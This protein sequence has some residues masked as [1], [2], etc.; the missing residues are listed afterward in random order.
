[1][2]INWIIFCDKKHYFWLVL[3]TTYMS[4]VFPMQKGDFMEEPEMVVPYCK[5]GSTYRKASY[6]EVTEIEDY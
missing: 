5:M 4:L 2:P 6:L 3:E 1:M